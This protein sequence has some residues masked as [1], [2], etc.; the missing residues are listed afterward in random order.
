MFLCARFV[1]EVEGIIKIESCG[2]TRLQCLTTVIGL[3]RLQA[4]QEAQSGDIN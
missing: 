1:K 3:S 2:P 4:S